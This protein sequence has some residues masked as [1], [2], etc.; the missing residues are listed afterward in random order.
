MHMTIRT[1]HFVL[2]VAIAMAGAR[3]AVAQV[4]SEE[5]MIID[6][7]LRFVDALE[8]GDAQA[9]EQIIAADTTAHERTRKVWIDLAISQKGLEK[10]AIQKFGEEG[11][12]FRCGFDL[13]V[14]GNDRRTIANARVHW[15]DPNAAH[16]ERPG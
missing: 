15:E 11:K 8:A 13:I 9:L 4:G 2:A 12:K 3:A 6:T 16:I 5:A 10:A 7:V 1:G 14:N